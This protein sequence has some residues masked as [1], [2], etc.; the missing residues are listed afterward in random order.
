MRKKKLN[1]CPFLPVDGS[2][3]W[4][5]KA[6]WKCSG[7]KDAHSDACIGRLMCYQDPFGCACPAGYTGR[8]CK[9]RRLLSIT[10]KIFITFAMSIQHHASDHV[11]LHFTTAASF[12]IMCFW[13]ISL[14]LC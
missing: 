11:V 4:G 1:V 2:N 9:E 3:R 14:Q 7:G 12:I 8:D 10:L 13:F 6:D 5:Q